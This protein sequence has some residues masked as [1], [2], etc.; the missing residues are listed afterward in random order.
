VVIASVHVNNRSNKI[1]LLEIDVKS[2]P[3]LHTI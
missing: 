2:M 3:L 1:D